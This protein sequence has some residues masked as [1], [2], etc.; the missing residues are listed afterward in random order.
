MA[1]EGVEDIGGPGE[2]EHQLAGAGVRH[3]FD[4]RCVALRR[5]ETEERQSLLLAHLTSLTQMD[6]RWNG[7][8]WLTWPLMS[9]AMARYH[10]V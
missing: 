3:A 9:A 2:V 6:M 8:L 5:H 10:A 1:A 7:A 4:L